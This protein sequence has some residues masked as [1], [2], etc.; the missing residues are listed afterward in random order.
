MSSFFTAS[1]LMDSVF[2]LSEDIVRVLF[3]LF[4][5]LLSFIFTFLSVF[6]FEAFLD[7]LAIG[8]SLLHL[9]ACSQKAYLN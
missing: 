8:Y 4:L 1:Y 3:T 5:L 9:T 6:I 2:F 7:C